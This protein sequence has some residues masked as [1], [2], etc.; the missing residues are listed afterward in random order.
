MRNAPSAQ[1]RDTSRTTRP[2]L[3]PASSDA[4][5]TRRRDHYSAPPELKE[6]LLDTARFRWTTISP[7][8]FGAMFQL[9]KNKEARR[10]DGEHYTSETNILKTLGPLFL[11]EARRITIAPA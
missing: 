10:G 11:D 3:S 2:A 4:G 1:W 5:R 7:A 6:V 9:V 8:I